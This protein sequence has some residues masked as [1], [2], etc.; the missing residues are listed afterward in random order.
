MNA[1]EV[2]SCVI[3]FRG[4][5]V[6]PLAR[7]TRFTFALIFYAVKLARVKGASGRLSRKDSDFYGKAGTQDASFLDHLTLTSGD[8]LSSWLHGYTKL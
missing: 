3:D 8:A 2:S 5:V 4:A 6:Q 7:H 1:V